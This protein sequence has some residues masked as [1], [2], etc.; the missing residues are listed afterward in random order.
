MTGHPTITVPGGFDRSGI[1]IGFQLVA[2]HL[3]ERELIT[4]AAVFQS[5]TA[6]H[7]RHPID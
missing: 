6:W 3:R 5:E 2:A 4:A 7:R 1:P